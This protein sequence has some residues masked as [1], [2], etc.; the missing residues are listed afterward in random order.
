MG[1]EGGG[2]LDRPVFQS[3]TPVPGVSIGHSAAFTYDG[4]YV[5]FGHEPGG[6]S[7]AQCQ[8]TSSVINRS[9]YFVEVETGAIAGSY[10]QERPQTNRENCTWHNLNATRTR[11]RR[12]APR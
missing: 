11:G 3:R 9:L 2:T 5:V 8:A 12:A 4:K 10:V 1:G 7:Q 6:G